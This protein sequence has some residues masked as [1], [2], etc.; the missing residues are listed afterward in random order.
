MPTTPSAEVASTGQQDRLMVEDNN[1]PETRF[2]NPDMLSGLV[3]AGANHEPVAE[4]DDGILY[5]AQVATL[6]MSHVD[7]VVLS[8]CE[9]GLGALIDARTGKPVLT[10]SHVTMG[11]GLIGVQRAFQVAGAKTVIASFWKVDDMGTERL[12]TRFYDNLWRNRMS[13]LD[14]LR[15]AQIWMMRD[16]AATVGLKRG[17]VTVV[18]KPVK[19][20]EK[21]DHSPAT[22]HP[23][24]WAPFVLSGD[25]R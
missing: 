10:A 18:P 21:D 2:E 19:E 5:S 8:A 7:L 22:S 3:F 13:K 14:A 12:M 4:D 6:P 23:R 25:W 20:H 17:V 11:D 15:E 9:T 16:A 1:R 24:Y